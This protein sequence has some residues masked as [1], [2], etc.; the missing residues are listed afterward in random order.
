M[1]P[2]SA[3]APLRGYGHRVAATRTSP[4]RF[5]DWAFRSR[6]DGRIVLVQWPNAPLIAWGLLTLLRVVLRP[7]GGLRTALELA[8][9]AALLLWSVLEVSSGVY[10]FRRALG[11]VVLLSVLVGL[12]SRLA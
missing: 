5:V 2:G 11:G 6:E 9:T 10:P 1:R 3:A 7:D 8:A 12:A 4:Q